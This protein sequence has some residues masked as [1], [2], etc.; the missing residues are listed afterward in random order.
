MRFAKPLQRVSPYRLV[1]V[2]AQGGPRQ[3]E[4]FRVAGVY[5]FKGSFTKHVVDVLD[6]TCVPNNTSEVIHCMVPHPNYRSLG[7]E[8][9]FNCFDSQDCLCDA[10]PDRTYAHK[11]FAWIGTRHNYQSM[12]S[13]IR[14]CLVDYHYRHAKHFLVEHTSKWVSFESDCC[15]G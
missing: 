7:Y 2:M 6:T 8:R 14:D 3:L 4:V 12:R 10:W 9:A 13:Y 1:C 15:W 11:A 5:D